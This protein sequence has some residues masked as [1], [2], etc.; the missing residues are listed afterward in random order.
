M[1]DASKRTY[2]LN[3]TC[4]PPII[5]QEPQH[6]TGVEPTTKL[7]TGYDYHKVLKLLKNMELEGWVLLQE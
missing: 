1:M 4:S 3:I 6:T 7:R 2:Q 5:Y